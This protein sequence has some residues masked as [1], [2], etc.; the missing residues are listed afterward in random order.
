MF[1]PSSLSR[2]RSTWAVSEKSH[3]LHE[4][5]SAKED[6]MPVEELGNFDALAWIDRYFAEQARLDYDQL[7]P[8]LCFSLIWNLF[9][10]V[11]CRR[12]ATVRS[13][14][15]AVDH[16]DQAGR[17]DRARYS[18]FVMFFRSRYVRD[19]DIE[20]AFERLLMTNMESQV[21]VRRALMGE[22]QD[23]NNIVFALLLIAHR[24]RN[25][26][27]HGNKGVET[28]HTQTE[29]FQVVNRLL[30]TFIED[31]QPGE[32]HRRHVYEEDG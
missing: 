24:I 1:R 21:A 4:I 28:L 14:R 19:G 9:E 25:N 7:R 26:L 16:A 3:D 20:H 10:T 32:L 6:A 8:I 18:K 11:A 29:L 13:I 5:L 22:A 23:M 15:Q 2:K 31:I 17:L 30:A 12:M 27:F